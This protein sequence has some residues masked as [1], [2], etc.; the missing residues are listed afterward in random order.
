MPATN[1]IRGTIEAL[2]AVAPQLNRATD[3]AAKLVQAIE[4][5]LGDELHV[6]ITAESSE[7][8]WSEEVD[9][10]GDRSRF[11]TT[12][13]YGRINGQFRFHVQ[14]EKI[15]LSGHGRLGHPVAVEKTPWSS[16]DREMKLLSFE[17]LPELLG[18]IADDA[19]ALHATAKANAATVRELMDA[20]QSSPV[21]P[22]L[23]D[24]TNTGIG[25]YRPKGG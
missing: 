2:R 6:G 9:D 13:A 22:A 1:D 5:I 21:P 8:D 12:L 17:K 23:G 20:L 14:V 11:A 24:S 18:N 4:A 16:C 19:I 3:E 25:D 7:I 15:A 10:D